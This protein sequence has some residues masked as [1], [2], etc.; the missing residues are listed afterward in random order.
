MPDVVYDAPFGASTLRQVTNSSFD[1]RIQVLDGRESGATYVSEKFIESSQPEAD[2]TTL[3]IAGFI[4]IFGVEGA[5]I[6]NGSTVKIPWHKRASGGTFQGLTG[7]NTLITGLALNPI[8]L[9]PMSLTAPRMGSVTA[10]GAAYFLSSDGM[11]RPYNMLTGQD[12]AAQDFQQMWGLGPVYVN[13]T[14]IDRQV[15]YSINFGVKYS[16]QQ[17]YDGLPYP[18]DIFVEDISPSIEFTAEDFDYFQSVVGG[19]AISQVWVYLRKRVSGGTYAVDGSTVHQKFSFSGGIMVPQ[20]VSASDTKHG[21][22]GIKLEGLQLAYS[23][24]VAIIAP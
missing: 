13:G 21:Q 6:T 23:S 8:R 3:D 11:T 4:S 7:V 22:A 9:T 17:H 10:Q 24:G 14:H 19:V 16:D 1:P 20:R 12:L 2:L 5:L 18:T 15:G